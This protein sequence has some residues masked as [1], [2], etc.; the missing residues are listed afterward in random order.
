[1]N[2]DRQRLADLAAEAP[3]NNARYHNLEPVPAHGWRE[4]LRWQK[5]HGWRFPPGQ[6]MPLQRPDD[7]VLRQPGSQPQITWLGHASFL[8]QYQGCNI[9]TDPVFSKRCSPLSLVGPKRFTPPALQL[10]ELPPIDLVVIS[11]NHYDHLD[12]RSVRWLHWRFDA[13]V[14]FLVPQGVKHWFDKQGINNVAELGWWETYALPALEACFVPAQHFSGR[15]LGDRNKTLWGGW[16]LLFDDFS[17]YF[18]GDTGYGKVFKTMHEALGAPD[19]A[20][21]PI[22]AYAP[23]WM[24]QG[25]HVDPYDA[26][27]IHC[28]LQAKQS[29][30]MH[31]GT[32]V[33]TDEPM[34]EPPRK[35]ADALAKKGLPPDCFSVMTHGE[36]RTIATES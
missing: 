31:W 9:L 22:G 24:M 3:A 1:M 28:D 30:G 4:F 23:R 13:Q 16:W 17:L 21:L 32:F 6:A 33:L 10:D 8:I 19:L 36:T 29:I 27:Q 2:L 15:G 20:L 5:E 12:K 25:V 18:A 26:V 35:L 34:D 7:K 14:H 11:H